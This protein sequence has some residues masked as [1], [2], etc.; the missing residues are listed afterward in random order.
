M[1]SAAVELV[2]GADDP[3]RD[4]HPVLEPELVVRASTGPVPV[5]AKEG[6]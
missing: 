4:Y 6:A 5:H 3:E 1:I 2:I